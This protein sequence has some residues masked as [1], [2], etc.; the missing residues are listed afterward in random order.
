MHRIV[1]IVGVILCI[2]AIAT[3]SLW[4]VEEEDAIVDQTTN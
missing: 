3:Y 2:A 1:V 4:P